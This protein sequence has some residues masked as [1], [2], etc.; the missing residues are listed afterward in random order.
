MNT[1]RA[2]R[3][4]LIELLVVIAIIAILAS[5]LLPALQ[6]AKAAASKAAC[7]NNLKQCGMASVL[8]VDDSDGWL[9]YNPWNTP[10]VN[11]GYLGD[12]QVTMCCANPKQNYPEHT[13]GVYGYMHHIAQT[14]AGSM[15]FTE[16]KHPADFLYLADS[17]F[18]RGPGS[19]HEN[20]WGYQKR[21]FYNGGIN[22]TTL[23]LRHLRQVN[24]WFAD[25]HA[26]SCDR[27]R[28]SECCRNDLLPVVLYLKYP[29]KVACDENLI[30][31]GL[32]F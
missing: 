18:G 28:L 21:V 7:L 11:S 6:Q 26:E 22:Y 8:Y 20:E 15:R 30:E 2:L 4:T 27:V 24:G 17:V 16:I 23:H 13:Y 9:K 3:F 14:A 19:G 31:R 5:L 32:P 29:F 1:R 12:T 10:L 25:G